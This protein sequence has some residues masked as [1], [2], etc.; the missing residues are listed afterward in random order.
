MHYCIIDVHCSSVSAFTA[1]ATVARMTK[2]KGARVR[3]P[4]PLVF[5]AGLWSGIA[6]DRWLVP[7]QLPIP[8]ALRIT[9]GIA[10]AA[11][12]VATVLSA[13]LLFL[14]TRQ[15]PT[16]WSPTP[17]LILSGPYRFTR[18]P[19]YVGITTFLVG[20]ALLTD[21][22]WIAAGGFVALACVHLI[23]VR[24]EEAYLSEKFGADYRVYT[25][26]VRRYL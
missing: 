13:R 17:E 23:A 9:I 16:P 12:G 25:R 2:P 18:N 19:M 20:I 3:F 1:I 11:C 6:V 4:P 24:P 10:I 22:V 7:T 15:C 21:V 26:R 14:R 5:L 8:S